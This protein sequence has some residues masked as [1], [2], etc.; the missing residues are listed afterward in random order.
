[1]GH[2]SA[3]AGKER[4][5]RSIASPDITE[6]YLYWSGWL[7]KISSKPSSSPVVVPLDI[8]SPSPPPSSSPT[9]SPR[10]SSQ[11]NVK[12]EPPVTTPMSL[13]PVFPQYPHI[14]E[15]VISSMASLSAGDAR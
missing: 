14:T 3:D 2:Y 12:L 9:K 11:A 1:M 5:H 4:K 6:G 13:Q 15:K 7:M 10:L 8:S